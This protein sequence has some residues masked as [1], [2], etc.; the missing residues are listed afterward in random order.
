MTTLTRTQLIFGINLLPRSVP[1]GAFR[2]SIL[3]SAL[4]LVAPSCFL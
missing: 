4:S 1:V 3:L 2:G